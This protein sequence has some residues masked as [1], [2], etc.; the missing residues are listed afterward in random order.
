VEHEKHRLT[1][2]RLIVVSL[3]RVF[4]SPFVDARRRLPF[5]LCVDLIFPHLYLYLLLVRQSSQGFLK[6]CVIWFIKHCDTWL[7]TMLA[8]YYDILLDFVMAAK[9]MEENTT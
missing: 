6:Y 9:V 1:L 7:L 5:H 8:R 4:R 3:S 2:F